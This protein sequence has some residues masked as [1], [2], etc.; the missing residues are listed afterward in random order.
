MAFKDIT[1]NHRIK[2]ILKRSLKKDKV[3]NSLLF[4]GPEG[5][6]KKEAALV[7]AKAMNCQKKKDDACE[8]CSSCKAINLGNFPDVMIISPEKDSLK[9]EQMRDLKHL[10]YLK[11]MFAKKRIFIIEEA[12][13]MGNE[14]A[15]SLLKVLE[16]PPLSSH[17]ILTTHNF[18]VILPTI[19]S[20]CQTLTFSQISSEEAEEF[21][22]EKGYDRERARIITFLVRGNLRDALILDWDELQSQRED[23]WKLLLSFLK[24]GKT[25]A[26]LEKFYSQR[27][28]DL[29]KNFTKEFE[30]FS[31]FCR[32][33]ILIKEKGDNNLLMNPD[34][35]DEL[36][37]V[38][39]IFSLDLLMEFLKKI[40]YVLY[41]IQRNLNFNLLMSSACY[42]LMEWS[43][44]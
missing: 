23:A 37:R 30:I 36:M 31:S 26:F 33:L 22:V 38:E 17:I 19:K 11:P 10:A 21:L 34:Y 42:D 25:S 27:K 35:K 40:D 2:K 15:N 13:K 9:I 4:C 41:G 6:G 14:A 29:M 24:N 1:G 32:D 7:L 44:V 43:H 5:V 28:S 18:Y 20:R 12:E 3:P 16:E 39:S 8:S